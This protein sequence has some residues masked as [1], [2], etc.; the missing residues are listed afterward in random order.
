[1][2]GIAEKWKELPKKKMEGIAHIWKELPKNG[3]N[4]Q[5]PNN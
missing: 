2:E 1:M 5:I 3:G 4:F